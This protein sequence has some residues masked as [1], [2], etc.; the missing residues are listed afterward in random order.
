M[1]YVVWMHKDGKIVAIAHFE[2][3]ELATEYARYC[4]KHGSAAYYEV[5]RHD[6]SVVRDRGN[7]LNDNDWVAQ[8]DIG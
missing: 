8:S 6:F 7:R 3:T 2:E 4:S 1:T 5:R